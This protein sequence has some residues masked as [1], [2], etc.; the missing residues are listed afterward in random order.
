MSIDP[1]AL[2]AVRIEKLRSER[3]WS[4]GDLAR[5]LA[6]VGCKIERSSLLKIEKGEPRRRITVNELV[7]FAAVFGTTVEDLVEYDRGGVRP[8]FQRDMDEAR[9]KIAE[10]FH[11]ERGYK[12]AIARMADGYIMMEDPAYSQIVDAELEYQESKLGTEDEDPM[13]VVILRFL[14]H[15]VQLVKSGGKGIRVT[16]RGIPRSYLDELIT[17]VSSMAAGPKFEG[18]IDHE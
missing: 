6:G 13:A 15:L 9:G 2:L 4:Y 18:G 16:V 7:G 10:Y 17:D 5:H 11:A 1:E 3:D 14:A 12:A 8:I